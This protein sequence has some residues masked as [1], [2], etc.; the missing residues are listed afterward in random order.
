[1]SRIIELKSGNS[2]YECGCRGCS[3]R[4]AKFDEMFDLLVR[5]EAM[6]DN[7][8][9]VRNPVLQRDIKDL[10]ETTGTGKP[11]QAVAALMSVK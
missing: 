10:L 9:N 4:R 11:K 2:H 7:S 5:V 1:M 8:S 3:M 6:L